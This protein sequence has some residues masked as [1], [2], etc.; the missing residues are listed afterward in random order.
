M[1]YLTSATV[2]WIVL[3]TVYSLAMALD[4]NVV[5]YELVDAQDEVH[6]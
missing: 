3:R 6:V 4:G 1:F 5:Q 2:S